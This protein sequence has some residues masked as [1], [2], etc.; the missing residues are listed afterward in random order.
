MNKHNFC[1]NY[2]KNSWYKF[3]ELKLVDLNYNS[4]CSAS[5]TG[6]EGL[7]CCTQTA[8]TT[9]SIAYSQRFGS[10]AESNAGSRPQLKRTYFS[11][12]TLYII[13]IL[14]F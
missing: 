10:V 8:G 7:S 14:K 13:F 3:N 2:P 12:L 1:I 9:K 5:V 11:H 4:S 6:A